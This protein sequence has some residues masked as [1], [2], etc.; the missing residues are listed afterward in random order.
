MSDN[1]SI[2]ASGRLNSHRGKM[3][4]IKLAAAIAYL[5]SKNKYLLDITC[6]FIPTKAV[7]TDIRA[8]F[9]K[10]KYNGVI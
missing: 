6:K 4:D 1:K 10:E 5:R 2:A 3:M 9:N 8:T 7:D